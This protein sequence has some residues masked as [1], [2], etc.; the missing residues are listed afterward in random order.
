VAAVRTP[1]SVLITFMVSLV[2]AAGAVATAATIRAPGPGTAAPS[3]TSVAPPA[4]SQPVDASGCKRRPCTV[5][6]TIAIAGSTVD[7]VADAGARSG[8][9]RIG[10]SGSGRVIE[11]RITGMGV[12]LTQSSLQCIAGPIS[13]CLI[14]GDLDGG[15]AGEVVVGRSDTW[16]A[17]EKPFQSDAGYLALSEVTGD[18]SPEIIAVQ[19]DCAGNEDSCPGRPV[20]AQV[21]AANGAEIGCTRHHYTKLEHLPGYPNIQLTA[22][23][24]DPC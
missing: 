19:H 1:R 8:R 17:L 5:L 14:R 15:V 12:R 11:T 22:A 21:F 4:T 13:A 20:Y 6:R 18:A 23:S 9:L 24:L 10:G 3:R 7:L 2:V 16:S